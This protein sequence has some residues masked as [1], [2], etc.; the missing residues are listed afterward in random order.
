MRSL[1][2][3]IY[4]YKVVYSPSPPPLPIPSSLPPL[5]PCRS[6]LFSFSYRF[7]SPFQSILFLPSPLCSTREV[8]P[9]P[10]IVDALSRIPAASDTGYVNSTLVPRCH[11]TGNSLSRAIKS[12]YNVGGSYHER[13]ARTVCTRHTPE[14]RGGRTEGKSVAMTRADLR[15]V[16]KGGTRLYLVRIDFH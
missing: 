2:V 15:E 14:P 9:V 3:D 13:D 10:L 6:I 7:P 12:A 5:S 1:C 4:T 16:L 11:N 8:I